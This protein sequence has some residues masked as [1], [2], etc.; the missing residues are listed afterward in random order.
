MA[1]SDNVVRAG[2]TPK[3]KDVDTLVG[4]L[5]YTP[6]TKVENIMSYSTR[7]NDSDRHIFMPPVPDFGV[8]SIQVG[9]VKMMLHLDGTIIYFTTYSHE[10]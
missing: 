2:L 4:M 9:L 6:K 7:D 10:I 1:T 3:F 5:D 8:H